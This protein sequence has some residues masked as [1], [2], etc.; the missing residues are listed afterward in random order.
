[1]AR[2]AESRRL[3]PANANRRAP[4]TRHPMGCPEFGDDSVLTRPNRAPDK[5]RSVAPGALSRRIA[6]EHEVVWWDPS[7][8]ILQVEEAMGLRQNKLLQADEKKLISLRG[9]K[10]HE[11][12]TAK[13][14]EMAGGGYRA[15]DYYSDGDRA[16]A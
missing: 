11:V 2:Q 9:M 6:G 12:W 7:R 8:L 1:M 3:Y 4:I 15:C 13:R 5:M 10:M 16:C 14:A